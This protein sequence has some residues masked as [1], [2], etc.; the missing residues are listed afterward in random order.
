MGKLRLK[1]MKR[2]AQSQL[3]SNRARLQTSGSLILTPCSHLLSLPSLILTF[4]NWMGPCNN[5][6]LF[7]HKLVQE[8]EKKVQIRG[9]ARE[10]SRVPKLRLVPSFLTARL[11][12]DS[13]SRLGPV[14]PS[15]IQMIII[16]VLEVLE[17]PSW[18]SENP[19]SF[20]K[21]LAIFPLSRGIRD[22][23][24]HRPQSGVEAKQ[25]L[26]LRSME[27]AHSRVLTN[28]KGNW[29]SR[30]IPVSWETF[31]R[32]IRTCLFSIPFHSSCPPWNQPL[33]VTMKKRCGSVSL[34]NWA[35]RFSLMKSFPFS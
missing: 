6:H 1:E 33:T 9:S 16:Q 4:S 25:G 19:S 18:A 11:H 24:V 35:I 21:K 30:R 8:E 2:L 29:W 32:S 34:E 20:V 13:V 3:E 14:L 26:C 15:P 22:F 7:G 31:L 10:R 5:H 27:K 23:V 17:P 12:Q 28:N